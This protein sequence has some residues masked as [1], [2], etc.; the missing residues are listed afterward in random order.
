MPDD[1][2][3]FEIDFDEQKGNE[4]K[5]PGTSDSLSLEEFA[6]LLKENPVA[7]AAAEAIVRESQPSTPV[8][9]ATVPPTPVDGLR[10][11]L[12]EIEQRLQENPQDAQAFAEKIK[13]EAQLGSMLEAQKMME[14]LMIQQQVQQA[15]EFQVP[16]LL[17][18]LKQ[19]YPDFDAYGKNVERELKQ[20]LVA[21]PSLVSDP[22]LMQRSAQLIADHYFSEHVRTSAKAG[23]AIR[24]GGAHIGGSAPTPRVEGLSDTEAALYQQAKQFY[25]DMTVDDFKAYQQQQGSDDVSE[26]EYNLSPRKVAGRTK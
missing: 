14:P 3:E 25:P 15:M 7:R 26:S 23:T 20:Q 17:E 1:K 13:L 24:G 16:Q 6:R 12:Q 10:Q 5:Q 4:S 22:T 11:K 18:S 2:N 9:Q 8:D 21:N 19:S